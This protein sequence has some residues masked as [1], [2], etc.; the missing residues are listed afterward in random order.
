MPQSNKVVLKVTQRSAFDKSHYWD[1]AVPIGA[2][3]PLLVDEVIPHSTVNLNMGI[4]VQLPPL[5]TDAI[6]KV[7]F[8]TAAFFVPSR[9][10]YGGYESWFLDK[11]EKSYVGGQATRT[12]KAVLPCFSISNDMEETFEGTFG[13]GTLSD[14]LGCKWYEYT[15]VNVP[16]S[17]MPYLAY[18]KIWNDYFRAPLVQQDIEIKRDDFAYFDSAAGTAPDNLLL[19]PA[20][21][22]HLFYDSAKI[23]YELLYDEGNVDNQVFNYADGHSIFDFRR[24]NYGYDYFTNAW[25]S[26]QAGSEMLV[27]TSDGE[28]SISSLRLL[29]SFQIFKERNNYAPRFFEAVAARYGAHLSDAIAQRAIFLGSASYNMKNYGVD[30]SADNNNAEY[31]QARFSPLNATAGGRA[32]RAIASGADNLIDHFDVSEPGYIMVIGWVAPRA[33]YSTGASRIMRRYTKGAGTL[34][35]MANPILQN[36]GNQPIFEYE[37]TGTHTERVFGFTD[38]YADFMTLPDRVFGMLRDGGDLNMFALQRTFNNARAV[39]I[40]SDF[41]SIAPQALDN[42][43]AYA[44]FRVAITSAAFDYKVVQPLAE[45]SIPSLQ[46]P[47]YEHGD[48]VVVHRG[49]LR[50]T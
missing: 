24:P 11:D 45:Y 23:D 20:R 17:L 13:L 2:C 27:D 39:T 26:P 4:N 37:L 22:N 25:P 50:L 29:N 9:I 1:G 42:I 10:L 43:L 14:A 12:G 36:I 15:S 48:S 21:M 44:N 34:V 6:A 40:S 18:H 19:A 7:D 41:L 5:A 38:R 46:D 28:F 8:K 47:A 33:V 35:E 16:Y 32:G 3:V 49:G 30:I 31:V